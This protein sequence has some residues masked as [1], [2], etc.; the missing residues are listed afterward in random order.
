MRS[1]FREYGTEEFTADFSPCTEEWQFASVQFSKSKYRTIQ[2]IRV[3]CDYDYNSGE[4]YFDDIQLVRNSLETS[5]AASDF[6]VESTGVSDDETVE[7]IDTTPTFSE[8]KDRFGNALTETTFTNGEFG[9][10]YRS[11]GFSEDGNDLVRETD[12]RGNNTT[13]TV[14]EETSRKKDVIDRLG[15]KTAYEYDD[16]GK[17]IKVTNKRSDDTEIANVSYTYDDFDNMTEITR[18]DGMKY[19]LAYNAFHNLESIGIN[20][21]TDGDL[22]KYTYKNGH[23]RLKEVAYTNGDKMTATYNAAGQLTHDTW[24]NSYGVEIARYIYTY[25]GQGNIVRS[26]DKLALKEYNYYYEDG[27]IIRATECDIVMSDA[28]IVTSKTVVNSIRYTYDSNGNLTKKI[29]T[30]TGE[31]P[32][33]YYYETTD[34]NTVVKFVAGGKNVTCHS[35]TDSFGRKEFDEIQTGAGFISR[36]FAYHV[37]MVDKD[38]ENVKNEKLKSTPTTQLVSRITLSNGRTLEYEYDAE[39]RINKV[40][41]SEEGTTE[42]TYDALGQMLT[43]KHKAVGEETFATVNNMI[44]NSYGNIL[45]KSGDMYFY[46]SVW[47]DRLTHISYNTVDT[48]G[49]PTIASKTITYDAQGNPTNYFGKPMTWEKGR[50]L[51]SVNT[52]YYTYNYTYNANGIRTGKTVYLT[53]YKYTLDGTKILKEERLYNGNTQTVMMPLYDNEDSVCGIMYNDTPY[54]FQKNL[55]GDIIAIVDVTGTVV[56]KYSYDAWGKCTITYKNSRLGVTAANP[57]RYRGYYLDQETG[58]YYLQSRYYDPST[59]RFI[60]GDEAINILIMHYVICS[61]IMSFCNNNVINNTD[62]FGNWADSYSG[63]VTTDTGFNVNMNLKFLSRKFCLNYAEDIIREYGKRKNIF[64]Q[65]KYKNMT[66]T[67]IAKEIWFHALVYYAGTPLQSF[68][69]SKGYS[70]KQLN[71]WIDSAKYIEV[72]NN[73]K[74]EIIFSLVWTFAK[75]VSSLICR[76]PGFKWLKQYLVI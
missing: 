45:S 25:D 57:F 32:F 11:F 17:I 27:R 40:V 28:E 9:T 34:D 33:T 54:Y 51:S 16:A 52:G 75:A 70:W 14:E 8:A 67:R 55:Q 74:R 1:F 37:G 63:F 68:L 64:S 23:G 48:E 65:K 72:N 42:Y 53:E 62:V 29:I 71:N 18:G 5:L 31:E 6:V 30:P 47:K 7:E 3:Y 60:N 36:Q 61:N 39:E 22:I 44:Y 12:A 73:D 66:A 20:G 10:I 59:G 76:T 2:Y 43:E 15:N 38:S 13:Y 46:D 41:D 49:N 56:G 35:K 21:K 58:F 4:V 19:N 26:I 69:K 50:Q 24:T